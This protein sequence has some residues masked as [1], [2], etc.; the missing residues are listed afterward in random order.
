MIIELAPVDWITYDGNRLEAALHGLPYDPLTV[1][2]SRNIT[3]PPA[4]VST[5]RWRDVGST[6]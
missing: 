1:K 3:A 6:D 5:R 2:P 4:G